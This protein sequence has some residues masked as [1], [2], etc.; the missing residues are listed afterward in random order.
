[1]SNK[2]CKHYERCSAPICPMDERSLKGIW[3]PDEESCM[4]SAYGN[5]S[6]IKAQ[7]KIVKASA[8]ANRYF[9]FEMLKINCFIRKGIIGLDPNIEEKPQL[10]RWLK[11]HPSKRILS[12]EEKKTRTQRIKKYQFGTENNRSSLKG[13]DSI[14]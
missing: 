6:W 1:M 8:Q 11:E 14:L 3:Y 13:Q 7:K 4:S 9:T 5:L 10:Q 12:E 2:L